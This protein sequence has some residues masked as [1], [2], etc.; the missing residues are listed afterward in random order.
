M[1]KLRTKQNYLDA[2]KDEF[3]DTTYTKKNA[4]DVIVNHYKKLKK[5]KALAEKNAEKA[6]KAEDE[7]KAK[8]DAKQEA[9][10][11]APVEV[12]EEPTPPV[13]VAPADPEKPATMENVDLKVNEK[14]VNAKLKLVAMLVEFGVKD[15]NPEMS[16]AEL[17]LLYD[18]KRKEKEQAKADDEKMASIN[19]MIDENQNKVRVE[20]G[21]AGLLFPKDFRR[22]HR[23]DIG[24]MK[25]RGND[26]IVVFERGAKVAYDLR[27]CMVKL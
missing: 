15:A 11:P 5:N 8:A 7:A 23:D 17:R 21:K 26:L 24:W 14:N 16:I 1:A 2:L 19:Q 13:E 10:A 12:D 25:V 18:Q 6:K 20:T 4:K 22:I 3:N 27:T 9:E